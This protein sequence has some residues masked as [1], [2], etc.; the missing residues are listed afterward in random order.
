MSGRSA[1]PAG[2]AG[3]D[4]AGDGGYDA[5]VI[6]GS[7]GSIEVLSE[8]LPALPA[9]LRAAVIVVLHLPRERR[10]LLAGIFRPRCALSVIDAQD[11][12][13]IAPGHLYFAP[14][15]YHLLVDQGPR[16]ALS[17]D[18]PVHYSR[19]SIDVLFESAAD[20]YGPRLI[21][22]LLSGA[23]QDGAA[24]SAAV[25]AAGG[26]VVV[27]QPAS[28]AMP[29]MPAAALRRVPTARVLAPAGIA[30]LIAGL[31]RQRRL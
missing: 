7:S 3:P 24:G 5:I 13:P 10:S 25:Q 9:G 20:C 19:P 6:G 31:H 18:A 21:S 16:L 30:D 29:T 2:A 23:N 11:Q 22:V 14:P 4:D 17:V 27:Q 28:A 26:Q 8:L 12:Q 1:L 15:D